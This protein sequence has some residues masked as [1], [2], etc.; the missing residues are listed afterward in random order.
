MDTMLLDTASWDM[1]LDADG[2]WAIASNPYSEAQDVASAIKLFLGEAYFDVSQGIPYF[3][4]IFGVRPN[5]QFVKSQ[6]EAAAL[7]VPGV[8]K[9]LCL[10]ASFDGRN[11][12]GQV[13]LIDAAGVQNNVTF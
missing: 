4:Q 8:V 2:N 12:T 10:F 13:Q 7:T 11:L 3:G 9:A 5:L 6:I 1:V